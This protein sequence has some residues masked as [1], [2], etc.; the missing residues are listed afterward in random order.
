M[1]IVCPCCAKDIIFELEALNPREYEDGSRADGWWKNGLTIEQLGVI[2]K[3]QANGMLEAL[4]VA[5]SKT[6][7]HT[8]KSMERFFLTFL[9]TA[10]PKRIPKF[11]LDALIAEFGG[12]IELWSAQ[13]VAG[14]IS[15][16][17]LVMFVPLEILCGASVS[18]SGG[19]GAFRV[20]ASENE[21][22]AWVKTK[23]G[24]VPSGRGLFLEEMRRKTIGE[25]A[26]P[27]L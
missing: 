1:R 7:I 22:Y 6:P 21:F 27:V 11:A 5:V 26:R 2:E 12:Q 20:K 4:K 18:A 9:K 25:F 19:S 3:A 24:Y 14:V 10:R 17:A 15:D 16:G 13:G 23:M 8:P